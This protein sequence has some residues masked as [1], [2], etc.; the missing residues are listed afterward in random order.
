VVAQ[1]IAALSPL[2]L[3]LAEAERTG[4]IP[5]GDA[6]ERTICLFGLLQGVLQLH[7]QARHARAVL[8]I[9][10][11]CESG[12]RTLLLG[13]GAEASRVDEALLSARAK[14]GPARARG[15]MK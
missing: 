4:H 10:R 15:G 14:G 9:D 2:S 13:F 3:A 7:K 11:L 8:D 12:V 1:M 5:R 6:A